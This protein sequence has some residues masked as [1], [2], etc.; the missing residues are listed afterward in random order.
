MKKYI[1]SK[2]NNKKIYTLFFFILLLFILAYF[3]SFYLLINKKYFIITDTNNI[4][5]F[6]IPN[7]KEGEK[8]K[9]INKKSIN[10]LSAIEMGNNLNNINEVEYT[11]QLFSDT[12]Y[13]NLEDFFNKLVKLKSLLI[14]KDDLFIFSIKSE[15]GINYFLTYKNFKTKNNAKSYCNNLSFVKKCLIVNLQNK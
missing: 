1:F 9:F 6:V 7:D 13:K 15:Y 5:Y 2:K 10:N 12:N 4:S 11:I 14:S 8:V 3:V